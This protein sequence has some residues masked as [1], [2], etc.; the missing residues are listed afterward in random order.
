[1][2]FNIQW[3]FIDSNTDGSFTVA[4]SNSFLSSD[5]FGK[6]IFRIILGKYIYFIMKMYVECT[7]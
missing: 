1:M 3:N 7:H 4:D 2:L 6:Q 5:S